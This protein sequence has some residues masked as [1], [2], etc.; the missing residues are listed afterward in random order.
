MDSIEYEFEHMSI[1]IKSLF[2]LSKLEKDI[3]I[4][5]YKAENIFI[6]IKKMSITLEAMAF[7]QDIK[8]ETNIEKEI[9]LKWS[10]EE[11]E[12]LIGIIIDNDI[13]HSYKKIFE[14]FHRA[15]KSRNRDVNHNGLDL[16]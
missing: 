7:E 2:S 1:L 12:R 13:K 6:I 8:I 4:N 5:S 9:I 3:W 15:D 10:K 14:R 11:I 16:Q